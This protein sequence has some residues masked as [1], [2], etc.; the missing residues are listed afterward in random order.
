METLIVINQENKT[1]SA[2]EL[3]KFLD[4]KK[5]FSDW[6]KYQVKKY[7]FEKGQDFVL[8]PNFGEQKGSGGHNKVDYAL[9]LETAKELSMVQGNEKGRLARKYFI[10]CEHIARELQ[11]EQ[12]Q[13]LKRML[14]L[15]GIEKKLIDKR[16][17]LN[18]KIRKV[19]AE[20]MDLYNDGISE[21]EIKPYIAEH[22]NNQMSLF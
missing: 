10:Q 17:G 2:R 19:R 14:E 4:V 15:A 12:I 1:V 16:K 6:F 13:G 5:D 22:L 8:L 18:H 3:Y 7:G 21:T 20:Y 11:T 9:S